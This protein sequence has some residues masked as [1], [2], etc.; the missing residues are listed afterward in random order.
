MEY[1]IAKLKQRIANLDARNKVVVKRKIELS[2]ELKAKVG[3]RESIEK[4]AR[5]LGF[6]PDNLDNLLSEKFT[7]T[8]ALLDKFD[9]DLTEVESALEELD[10]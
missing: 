10:Q 1:D 7:E 8:V 4:E 5:K 9:A 3:E 6:D 2:A